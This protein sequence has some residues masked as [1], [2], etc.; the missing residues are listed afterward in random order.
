V[1]PKHTGMTW[2]RRLVISLAVVTVL[3][4]A[5][6]L[7]A[8]EQ[9][10]EPDTPAVTTAGLKDGV[11]GEPITRDGIFEYT[12]TSLDCGTGGSC[13]VGIAVR[14]LTSAARKPGISF[15][16]GIDANGTA[17][18]ADAVAEIKNGT[19]LLNDLAAGARIEDRLYYD[20]P[21]TGTLT[22][23]ELRESTTSSGI[24]IGLR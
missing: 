17:H 23:I 6:V 10:A 14:N 22:A 13:V 20:V 24:R 4:G 15:A 7:T 16:K 12:V 18:L 2:K 9:S 1:L 21:A 3:A 19:A 11:M 8:Y 5:G